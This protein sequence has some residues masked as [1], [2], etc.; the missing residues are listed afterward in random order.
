MTCALRGVYTL[1]KLVKRETDLHQRI[2]GLSASYK[3]Q[4]VQWYG[5]YVIVD[6]GA[7]TYH[8]YKLKAFDFRD[9]DGS[10]RCASYKLAMAIY[11]LWLPKHFER[12]C[13][14]I[15]DIPDDVNFGVQPIAAPVPDGTRA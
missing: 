3:D 10:D 14:A 12:L 2:L 15:D 13:S 6:N 5:H 4:N 11:N 8:R 7:I 9:M 1:F